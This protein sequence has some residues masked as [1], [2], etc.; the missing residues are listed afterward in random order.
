MKFKISIK[1][2]DLII[3]FNILKVGISKFFFKLFL[4]GKNYLSF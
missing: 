4:F 1:I 2:H 3:R